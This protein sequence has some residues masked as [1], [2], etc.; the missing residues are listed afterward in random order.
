[1][2]QL[3]EL[4][5]ACG[6]QHGHGPIMPDRAISARALHCRCGPRR[7]S[8]LRTRYRPSNSVQTV[9]QPS[10]PEQRTWRC[11]VV[12]RPGRISPVFRRKLATNH[13]GKPP[14]QPRQHRTPRQGRRQGASGQASD[15]MTM[16]AFDARYSADPDDINSQINLI[17]VPWLMT[18]E[19]PSAIPN[20][21]YLLAG[22]GPAPVTERDPA[23][24]VTCERI[25][26]SAWPA[27]RSAA[28]ASEHRRSSSVRIGFRPSHGLGV[29]SARCVPAGRRR[30]RLLDRDGP[31]LARGP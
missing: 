12:I 3:P 24:D 7:A 14:I 11:R 10:W 15:R 21:G 4:L 22:L 23:P 16:R 6:R 1:M 29:R 18:G 9:L 19:E 26:D 25:A 27:L 28:L 20:G 5:L 17:G 13:R 2:Q 8:R 30:H 31:G